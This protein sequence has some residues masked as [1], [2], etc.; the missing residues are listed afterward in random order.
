MEEV[1]PA[2]PPTNGGHMCELTN[3]KLFVKC[4]GFTIFPS[5]LTRKMMAKAISFSISLGLRDVAELR[6]V[7]YTFSNVTFILV[8]GS[9]LF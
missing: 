5:Q 8:S 6:Y 2:L 1:F 7:L 9:F 4:K 3:R